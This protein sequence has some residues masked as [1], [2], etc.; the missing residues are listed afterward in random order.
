M[1]LCRFNFRY[2]S[3]YA[4]RHSTDSSCFNTDIHKESI[5]IL[6]ERFPGLRI[7]DNPVVGKLIS[8]EFK[9]ILNKDLV[10]FFDVFKKYNYDILIAGGA[11]R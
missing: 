6:R 4:R 8:P 2:N 5:S 9:L 11:V 7:R 1:I 3:F 10:K